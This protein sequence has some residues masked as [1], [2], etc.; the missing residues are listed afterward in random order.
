MPVFSIGGHAEGRL[1]G[2][3]PAALWVSVVGHCYPTIEYPLVFDSQAVGAYSSPIAI[4]GP[5]RV[6]QI[7]C[8]HRFEPV[9]DLVEF[10]L[11][12]VGMT[13]TLRA[14]AALLDPGF[15]SPGSIGSGGGGDGGG[16]VVAA[17]FEE[18][19]KP[20][21]GGFLPAPR[22]FAGGGVRR[23]GGRR[24]RFWGAGAFG[25]QVLALEHLAVVRAAGAGMAR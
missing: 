12:G 21:L 1:G 5:D 11:R 17:K 24:G 6:V 2:L 14:C 8:F 10:L 3:L 4:P 19:S 22:V 20:P 9:K 13:F 7:D 15:C 18:F 23:G 16:F 25:A